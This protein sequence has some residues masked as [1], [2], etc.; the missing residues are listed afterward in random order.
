MFF[1]RLSGALWI[2]FFVASIALMSAGGSLIGY[3]KF[4]VYRSG[5]FFSFGIKTVPEHLRGYYCWG[6]RVFFS[7]SHY[8]CVCYYQGYDTV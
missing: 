3:A 8:R 2:W 4:R 6:W 5:Q 1:V 7:V